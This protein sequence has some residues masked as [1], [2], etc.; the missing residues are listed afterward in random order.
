MDATLQEK[1]GEIKRGT[2]HPSLDTKEQASVD[3]NNK[4]NLDS[5]AQAAE[6]EQEQNGA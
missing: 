4:K 5:D 1:L 3:D 2:E 6:T